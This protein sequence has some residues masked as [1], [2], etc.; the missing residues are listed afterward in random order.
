VRTLRVGYCKEALTNGA[1]A[2]VY[3]KRLHNELDRLVSA[4]TGGN[5]VMAVLEKELIWPTRICSGLVL[6]AYGRAEHPVAMR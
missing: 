5:G 3:R 4:L 1:D 6:A 2:V